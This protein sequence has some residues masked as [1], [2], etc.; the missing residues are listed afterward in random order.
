LAEKLWGGVVT[1]GWN[2]TKELEIGDLSVLAQI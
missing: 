1:L 2:M